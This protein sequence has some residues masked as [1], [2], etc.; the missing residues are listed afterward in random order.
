MI[1]SRMAQSLTKKSD[2]FIRALVTPGSSVPMDAK[3]DLNIGTAFIM[4]MAAT[5]TATHM[6]IMG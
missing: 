3:V 5:T 4:T 1:I 6:T 2:T